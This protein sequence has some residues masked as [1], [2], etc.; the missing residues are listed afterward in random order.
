MITLA[1]DFIQYLPDPAIVQLDKVLRESNLIPEVSDPSSVA[2]S[3]KI[4]E[5]QRLVERELA[6]RRKS[7]YDAFRFHMAETFPGQPFDRQ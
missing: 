4:E 1:V 6:K 7:L 2:A 5:C 3:I